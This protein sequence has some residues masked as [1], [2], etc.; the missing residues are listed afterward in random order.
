MAALTNITPDHLDRYDGFAAYA[1]SKARLFA[2]QRADQFAVFGCDD[3]PTRGDRRPSRRVA[4]AGRI[5]QSK[6]RR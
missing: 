3:A 5:V 6:P 1:A 2:M 4:I